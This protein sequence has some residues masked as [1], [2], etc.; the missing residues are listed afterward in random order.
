[1]NGAFKLTN[2][3]PH[4]RTVAS[5][6]VFGLA[7]A[8]ATGCVA[9]PTPQYQQSQIASQPASPGTSARSSADPP[10][11]AASS[12]AETWAFSPENHPAE[13]YAWT[14]AT[15]WPCSVAS[16]PPGPDDSAMAAISGPNVGLGPASAT[17]SAVPDGAPSQTGSIANAAYVV[18]EM[19]PGFLDCYDRLSRVRS[20]ADG[21]IG[22]A[23]EV[24]CHG[25]VVAIEATARVI[26]VEAVRCMLAVAEQGQFDPPNG[27]RAVIQVPIKFMRQ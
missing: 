2:D 11:R 23:I 10:A 12:A 22:F 3:H 25:Q 19:R 26:E 20:N 8:A 1:M 7:A 21:S 15:H 4:A 5:L 27:G 18:A 17:P 6:A 13:H 16:L 14:S 24:N 9:R